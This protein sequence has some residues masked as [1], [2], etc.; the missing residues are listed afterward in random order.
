MDKVS[1]RVLFAEKQTNLL[2]KF[3]FPHTSHQQIK[4][5]LGYRKKKLK[6]ALKHG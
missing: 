5:A 6:E 3:R 1:E 2:E 4:D